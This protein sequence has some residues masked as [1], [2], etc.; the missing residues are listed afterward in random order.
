MNKKIIFLFVSILVLLGYIFKIDKI[1]QIQFTSFAN[2]IKSTYNTTINNTF[3]T[4]QQYYNQIQTIKHLQ[5]EYNKSKKYELLY[6]ISDYELNKIKNIN[7]IHRN[8]NWVKYVEVLSYK[9]LND[10]TKVILDTNITKKDNIFAL[11]TID[12]YSAGIVINEDNENI[13]YLNP[14]EKCNY[15]VFIGKNLAPGITSGQNLKH[16]IIINYI[17]KW[18]KINVNDVV[19]TSGMDDIFPKGLKLGTVTSIKSNSNT[20]TA[21]I[22]PYKNVLNKKYFYIIH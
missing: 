16:E 10:F 17:P 12:G 22:K 15:A 4:I 6:K 1:I 19:V 8:N 20:Q 18:H 2:N 13:A 3:I 7:F 14:N 5:N 11:A 9:T 21:Y